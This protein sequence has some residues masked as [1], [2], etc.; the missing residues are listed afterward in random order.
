M[1]YIRFRWLGFW[2][3]VVVL[4]LAEAS[5]SWAQGQSN[6][7]VVKATKHAIAPPL[8]ETV[9][10]PPRSRRLSSRPDD[11]DRPRMHGPRSTT[12]VK[13][14][15]LQASPDTIV[16]SNLSSLSTNSGLNILG[17]GFGFP[18]YTAQANVPD[19]S[20]A[21]GPTQFVQWVNE[22]FA[23][24]NKSDGSLAF[25]PANGNTLWQAL[26]G[27]C[28][29]NDNLDPVVQFDKLANRW[30]MTM[31]I[32]RQPSYLCV[33]VSTTSDAISGGW[34]LYAFLEPLTSLCG[35]CRPALDYPKWAVWPDGYYVTYVQGD[36]SQVFIGAAA[37]A[38]DRNSML[39]GAAATMQCFTKSTG[40]SFGTLLPADVDGVTPPP[41][42]SPEYLL[43]FDYNDQSLDLWQFH[44]DWT[45][46]ANS[47][48]TG[49][50]NIPVAAFT[51]AC[52]E[53]VASLN[54]TT[55]ACVP[56]LG[57][58]QGLDSY[59]D[60]LMFRLAYRN[61]GSH[62]SLIAN[63]TVT[64]GTNGSQTG[65][66]W[67]ELQNTGSGFGL[68]QQGTYAPD[69]SYRWMGS[70]AM[71]KAGDM[72]LGYSVSSSTMSPSIRYTGRVASDPSGQMEGEVDV[73]S[74]A[75][76]ANR[77]LTTTLH[78]GDYSTL[79]VDPKD[80]CTFWY[81]TEY[82]P[83]SSTTN[84]WSTR[85]A[86]FSFPSCLQTSSLTVN[87]VGQGTVTSTDGSINCTNGTG[88]C[89]GTYANGSS[90]SMNATAAT[91]WTF[92]GWS[93]SCTGS[94]PCNVVMNS[95]LSATA[96]FKQN[97]TLRVNEV[98]QGTVTSTDGSINCTNGSGTC[99]AV[100]LSGSTVTMNATAAAGSTFSGWSGACS[101]G[102]PC[103]VVMTSN[104]NAT[105]TFPII[106]PNFT[107]TV[108]ETGQGT[109]TSTDGAINCTDGSGT[110]SAVYTGGSSVTLNATSATGW[111]FTGWSGPCSGRNPCNVTMNSN[112][113]ATA[114]FVITPAW[115]IVH[116]TS[117]ASITSLTIPATGSGNL[118]AV[119]LMFNGTTSVARVSDDAGNAYVSAGARA[120]R[121]V[122]SVEIWYA[123]NSVAGATVVTPT[124]V[125]SPTHV[126]ITTW[127]VS[128][129]LSMPPDA[130]NTASGLVTLTNIPGPAV[131]TTQAS[132]FIVS[133][134][135]AINTNVTSLGSGNEFTLD[136]RT[137]A[138]GWAHI[139][140]NSSS[141]GTHQASWNMATVSGAYCAS[142]VA[143]AP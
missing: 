39:S 5:F 106:P 90:V 69:S 96:S 40:T 45:T 78:W 72:A 8:S 134:L 95:N 92:S 127:E 56:Q 75:S 137:N 73:L 21:V 139:T 23:V 110:C 52:G 116:K 42:G 120:A 113:S 109:V 67:Y 81:T 135:F 76:V 37:C 143:F 79:A 133:I 77:S 102:N 24:F 18:G 48:F 88:S 9:P 117:K 14:S 17:L 2:G 60:R 25:G 89:G 43:S 28:A 136:F 16:S 103:N 126:E 44:V 38:V 59:G 140:S 61:F 29:A 112:L 131:T 105:A 46:P 35:G 31:P 58:S 7:V 3:L 87:E 13:D 50:T 86:S 64:T 51:E 54:Y 122:A 94:N 4:F 104:L 84:H 55:G 41:T 66:R 119:A 71:D 100:Y 74:A 15:V 82:V 53:T 33:A 85:I 101:G 91:G 125:G 11:D 10:L 111:T 121:G 107:L 132:D 80:D 114:A 20:I 65:I 32:F 70:I 108:R 6:T 30:V 47:T 62:Q 97:F 68:F 123:L 19:S 138:N 12:P 34:N 93:G 99:S 36:V 98:G 63:H 124:F 128:G 115:A 57:T 83:L 22:S 142:T 129:I 118:I 1:T 27:P 49:P 26:G 141:A 130:T